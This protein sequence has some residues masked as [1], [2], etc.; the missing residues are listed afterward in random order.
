[1]AA[2]TDNAL[3]IF[4]RNTTTGKLTAP[5]CVEDGDGISPGPECAQTS[6][7]LFGPSGVGVTGDGLFVYTTSVEDAVARFERAP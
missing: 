7:G 6:L 4:D 5:R 1:M 3:A 2:G